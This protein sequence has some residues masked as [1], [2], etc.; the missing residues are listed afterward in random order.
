M[1]RILLSIIIPCYNSYN[2]MKKGL[3]YLEK[4]YDYPFEV[5]VVDDC[6]TDSSYRDL[7]DYSNNS[8]LR[9][10]VLENSKNV[11][12]GES[13]N[14]GITRASGKYIVFLDADDWFEENFF[15]TI[16]PLLRKDPDCVVFDFEYVYDDKEK[17]PY[18]IFYS[19][20]EVGIID[21][22]KALVFVRSGTLGKVYKRDI[23]VQN[24]VKFLSM[25]KGEDFPFTKISVSKCKTIIYTDKTHYEYY[26]HN[27]SL[28]HTNTHDNY[29]GMFNAFM[30]IYKNVYK[31]YP[32]E[33]EG[34]F[35]YECLYSTGISTTSLLDRHNWKEY[36][37]KLESLFPHY[38]KN[39]YLPYFPVRIRVL[40]KVIH[41]R[42]Y[43]L[44]KTMNHIQN[45]IK[46]A[47]H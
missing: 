2:L 36:I 29:L 17:Q 21:P 33:V 37:E 34:I 9:I 32:D 28:M 26:Q 23:I 39:P 3:S 31:D 5:V 7:L 12:P 20:Q 16:F 42:M 14:F 35:V 11:G 25:K 24:G 1:D 41:F 46:S 43:N 38:F 47:I 27:S 4:N 45:S 8:K 44:V 19:K 30:E 22:A 13:R 15:D 18:S 10:L 40:L 6:S